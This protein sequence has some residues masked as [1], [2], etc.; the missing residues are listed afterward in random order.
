MH[1]RAQRIKG[2]PGLLIDPAE[3]SRA[4]VAAGHRWRERELGP[5]QTLR[6]MALQ[7]LHGNTAIAHVVRL[8]GGRFSESA[9]C[10]ARARLPVAVVRA[11]LDAFNAGTDQG[12]QDWKGHRVV[13]IDGT[14]VSTPDTPQLR[15]CVGMAGG[16]GDG[17]GLPCVKV[18]TVFRARDGAL[19][20]MHTAP[21]CTGDLR[22]ARDLHPALA[23]GDVLVGDRGFCAYVHLAELAARGCHGLF[24]V[25]ASRA[26]P[27]PARTGKRRPLGGKCGRHRRSEPVLVDLI[28]HDDQVV[29]LVKPHNRPKSM[30]PE[31]FAAIPGKLLVRAVRYRVAGK[32]EGGCRTRQ[33]TLLTTLIDAG[34]YTAADLAD[35]YKMRWRVEV[36]LRHL[37]R[38][39]GMDRLRCESV[40]GVTREALMLALIYN[41]VCRLRAAA[42]AAQ[43]VE[44]M[45]LSFIDALR[46]LRAAGDHLG[47][48]LTHPPDLKLWPL[49][50]PRAHPRQLKRAHSHFPILLRPRA[51]YIAWLNADKA[52]N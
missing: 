21:A 36:N 11:Q 18:L 37:K 3:V 7:M 12:G 51:D 42:A 30:T 8:C 13:L 2:E 48:A 35:L 47:P 45:R 49:R 41:A 4:C 22:H 10:Q 25:Q 23:P 34:R 44:P 39:I 19:L 27:F 14:G 5:L 17:R 20:D 16:H 32:G 28:A 24:R 33:V 52:V 40:D 46:V 26:L 50:P 43:G 1:D 15:E 6:A 31:A 9:Y 29:E 38:T